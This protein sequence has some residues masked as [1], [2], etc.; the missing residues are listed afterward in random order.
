MNGG[1]IIVDTPSESCLFAM[2]GSITINGGTLKNLCEDEY[3][4][5]GGRT[6][7]V[8]I[9]NGTPG[10]LVI[11][12][13]TF[14]GRNPALGDDNL[15]GTFIAEDAKLAQSTDENGN[16]VYVALGQDETVAGVD[17]VYY[18]ENDLAVAE[19]Y[20]AAGLADALAATT[21]AVKNP[22][23]DVIRLGDDISGNIVVDESRTLTIDLNG[24]TLTGEGDH[25]IVN[26]GTLTVIDSSEAKS[27]AVDNVTHGRG[28]LVNN[29]TATLNGGTFKRSAEAGVSATDNGGNSWYGV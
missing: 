9:S 5:G 8:N 25:T 15:G 19:V 20:T 16:V 1:T 2:G 4:Y 17:A 24:Y 29:G 22:A 12:G 28:A 14:I 6:Q 7:V 27:G 13:G 21:G 10:Q 23:Y 18:V 26:N 3:S 11:N